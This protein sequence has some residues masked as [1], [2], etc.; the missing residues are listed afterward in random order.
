VTGIN[1][2]LTPPSCTVTMTPNSLWPPN[3]KMVPVTASV[4]VNDAG[5]GPNGFTLTSITSNEGNISSEVQGFTIGQPS[6]GGELLA[7][8]DGT[9]IGRVY[10]LTYTAMDKV[11]NTVSCSGV[12]RVPH[13]QG[14]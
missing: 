3:H 2:D 8:R 1:V 10:T 5:S 6:T 14:T 12:V 4:V 7:E 11:G 9:G 13:D